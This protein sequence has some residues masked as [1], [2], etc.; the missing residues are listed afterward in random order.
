MDIT[1]HNEQDIS[2][3]NAL[4]F[5][6]ISD[7]IDL[8][9]LPE[10]PGTETFPLVYPDDQYKFLHETA[11]IVYHGTIFCSWYNNPTNELSGFTPIRSCRSK[12]GGKTWSKVETIASDP[13][14]K[15]LYCPPVYGICD[16]KLY[17]LMNTMVSADHMHSLE[18]YLYDEKTETFNLIRS[19]KLPFK[20]NT[21]V[22]HLE[23]GKLLLP[24]RIAEQDSFPATPAVLISD[25]GKI[26]AE[27]RLVYVQKD[28][29][30]PGGLNLIH[31]EQSAI[32]QQETITLFCRNCRSAVPL[33]FRSKDY[34]ET[35]SPPMCHNIPFS[36]SKIYSGTLKDGRH[37]LI[38][39]MAEGK[40]FDYRNRNKL[41]LFITNDSS[42]NFSKGFLIRDGYDPK[43]NLYP[44]WSYPCAYEHE[45]KLYVIYTMV[46]RTEE[47]QQ[48]G[49][50]ISII[51]T[52]QL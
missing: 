47:P 34:G 1:Y 49:A 7:N 5:E 27:W 9:N 28:E 48:R 29:L 43:W 45:G 22:Y 11:I 2:L 24:G 25:S 19:E 52:A 41:A 38:G 8:G 15:L 6:S 12:D 32:I 20:L 33:M 46:T 30:L 17:M 35:W 40:N 14:G 36:S 16:D 31:P 4:A 39:N 18:F 42:L 50:M 26:D 13:S 10:I 3:R 44:Q 21:N 37:Y 51:D 23:N